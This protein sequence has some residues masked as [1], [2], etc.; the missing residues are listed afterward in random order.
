[1]VRYRIWGI[2]LGLGQTGDDTLKLALAKA[3][4][5]HRDLIHDIHVV[6]RSLDARKGRR[7]PRW[8]FTL[9]IEAEGRPQRIPP[10]VRT[11]P[12]PEPGPRPSVP[13]RKDL[14]GKE[15]I[16]VG[17]GPAGLFAALAL[18]SRGALVTVL[19]QGPP[20]RD[21]VG[22]VAAL[23]RSGQL[24]PDANVQFGEGGAGTFS[25][26]KLMTRVRDPLVRD[27]LAAFVE[28]GAPAHIQEDGHPH[29][30]TDGVRAAVGALR[31]RLEALGV[32]FHF[33]AS[34]SGV[35]R[36]AAGYRVITPSGEIEAASVFLAVGHSSRP[37]F[38]ALGSMGLPFVAK[39]FAVGVR[40]EHPQEWI[41]RCQYGRFAGHPELPAAEYFLTYKDGATGRGVYSFC[42]CPGGLV[43]NSASEAEGL[44][45]NGMSL[46]RRVSGR[47][48]AGIVVTVSPGDFD[49]D[50]WKG[51]AFQEALE[52]E[53]FLAG[54]G[55]FVAP[56]QTVGA[57]LRDRKDEVLPASTFRPGTRAA[58][59]RGFFPEWIEAPLAR[60]L[61]NF[62]RKMPGFIERG[63]MLAP[64]TRTSSPLQVVRA[65]DRSVEG[66]PGLYLLGEGGG[67]AGGIVSSAVDALRCVESFG[68]E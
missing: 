7:A 50:P 22:A 51:L 43:V 27:V 49:G 21:R 26:G 45:T 1:M 56:A 4:A 24:H 55:G 10:G 58:N 36:K 20:L 53:G 2:E 34:V 19:E 66:F 63:L 62:D 17:T 35:D 42:M 12:V 61:A 59:L 13:A 9:D 28:A 39:G 8:V 30:G 54:G 15:T 3:L 40:V 11:G 23:W 60:A 57:F 64:E 52:R 33:R 37:L 5:I 18:S 38:R 32:S 14:E 46:S 44:V 47:G 25:D 67:W 16:V 6:R 65:S 41:D 29:L 31:A 68:G 48:N